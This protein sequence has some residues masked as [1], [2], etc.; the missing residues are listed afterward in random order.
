MSQA[1]ELPTPNDEARL[2]SAKLSDLIKDEIHNTGGNISF[3]RYMEM[4][5]Y[6][7]GLGY[8]SAGS[9]K[10]GKEGDFIT[11][12]EISG[13]FS[14]CLASQCEEV[15]NTLESGDILELGAGKG[16]MACDL[17][18]ALQ[19]TACL[20]GNYFILETSADLRQRQQALLSKHL[21]EYFS[22]IVWL[23]VLPVRKFRG[24][25]LANEVIDSIPVR[26]L[27]FKKDTVYELCVTCI[28]GEFCYEEKFAEEDLAEFAKKIQNN[29]GDSRPESYT[30]EV[31][32]TQTGLIASLS[33]VLD[34]GVML[35]IDYGYTEQEYYHPLRTEGS[36]L[37]HYRH[38]VHSDPFF[39]PGLQDITASVNFSAVA[40]AALLSGL[41]VSGYTTQAHFLLSTG[42][43]GMLNDM[44]VG[45]EEYLK[46]SQE[47]KLLTLP[48]E[49]GERFKVMALTKNYGAHIMGFNLLDQRGR[50]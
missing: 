19:Q 44:P 30:T 8:Y 27:Q 31:N 13:L 35:F 47:I 21:P 49:M 26:R 23:D 34:E 1:F 50:L 18:K 29:W 41:N 3:Q 32:L 25:I 4:A 48:E 14:R 7:P 28:D 38:R 37:C 20:P 5:L 22:K 39:Y 16:T 10:I 40:D 45:S 46:L 12:P 9:T 24:L 15:L 36:L 43:S 17:L 2:H 11:A 42:L 33:D 6:Q